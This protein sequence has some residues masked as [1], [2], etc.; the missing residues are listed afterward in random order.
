MKSV[1]IIL[2][3]SMLFGCMN[4]VGQSNLKQDATLTSDD[5]AV[6]IIGSSPQNYK[7]SFF[8]GSIKNGIFHVD[9]FSTLAGIYQGYPENGYIVGK[10]KTGLDVAIINVNATGMRLEIII[11]VMK[12]ELYHLICQV[13]VFTT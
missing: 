2:F 7:V 11:L 6:F 5:E 9:K 8:P 1:I 3:T 4:N 10:V 13:E 12:Y